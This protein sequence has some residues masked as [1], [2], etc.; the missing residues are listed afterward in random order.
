MDT[1]YRIGAVAKLTG[2]S[3]DTIRAWERRYGVV[4]P[5]RGENNNRC[6]TEAHVSKLISVKRLVDAGQAIGT[7]CKLSEDALQARTRGILGPSR[8]PAG[9][10][11]KK[12]TVIS[13]Q[14]PHWLKACVQAQSGIEANWVND[15]ESFSASGEEFVVIDIPSLSE[16]KEKLVLRMLPEE[17]SSRCLVVY[18]FA[19]R[20]QLRSL[21]SKGI[22]LLKGPLEPFA[23]VNLLR[24]NGQLGGV[25]SENPDLDA[26][27]LSLQEGDILC[28]CKRQLS[29]LMMALNQLEASSIGRS[30]S[31]QMDDVLQQ[32]LVELTVQARSIMEQSLCDVTRPVGGKNRKHT[33]LIS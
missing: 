10:V 25:S 19:S 11:L 30:K 23:L 26:L 32:Q 12:W 6:Y 17:L 20:T 31:F 14:Q 28:K 1:G 27:K 15:L 13:F 2:I 24:G 29:G 7:I 4:Q 9:G 33:G 16:M 18:K 21:S 3:T 22:R 5:N 8:Q